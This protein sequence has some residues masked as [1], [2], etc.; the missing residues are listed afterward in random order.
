[1]TTKQPIIII[2]F[3]MMT[4]NKRKNKQAADIICTHASHPLHSIPFSAK[5][6]S[7]NY[8]RENIFEKKYLKTSLQSAI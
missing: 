6:S 4:I 1:M 5:I 3:H 2:I 7:R 8:L